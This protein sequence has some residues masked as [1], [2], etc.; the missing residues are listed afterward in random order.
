[1]RRNM[2]RI[3]HSAGVQLLRA[4]RVKN[5]LSCPVHVTSD[6]S[7][8]VECV[9]LRAQATPIVDR[10]QS[11][12]SSLECGA[13]PRPGP[14]AFRPTRR[15]N[16]HRPGCSRSASSSPGP[17]RAMRPVGAPGQTA[18]RGAYPQERGPRIRARR[19]S[20]NRKGTIMHQDIFVFSMP[21]S[22]RS[23]ILV[24]GRVDT[25]R[26]R[27]DDAP[28][29]PLPRGRRNAPGPVTWGLRDHEPDSSE[30]PEAGADL[31]R[32]DPT[33]SRIRTRIGRRT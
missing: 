25:T 13:R 15:R 14:S 32:I 21:R 22:A 18:P 27:S 29:R 19:K 1:M 12:T 31:R 33:E 5:I 9:G 11:P 4:A 16:P 20:Q 3:C 7:G 28:E 23:W 26:H 2:M 8:S 6:L 10:P 17:D 24:Q 30:P